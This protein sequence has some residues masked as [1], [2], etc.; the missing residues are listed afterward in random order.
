MMDTGQRVKSEGPSFASR[1][2]IIVEAS[3]SRGSLS[4]RCYNEWMA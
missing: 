1:S 2:G 4:E 3:C